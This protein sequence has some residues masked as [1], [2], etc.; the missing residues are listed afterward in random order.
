MFSGS[1]FGRHFFGKRFF[2]GG[3][4]PV[5]LVF[6]TEAGFF[7]IADAVNRGVLVNAGI[8]NASADHVTRSATVDPVSRISQS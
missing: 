2:G 7:A 5:D 6:P 4:V 8:R 1:W 3:F